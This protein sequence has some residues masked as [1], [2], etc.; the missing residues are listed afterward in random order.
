MTSPAF[1]PTFDMER[2]ADT[3]NVNKGNAGGNKRA[4]NW[5]AA[6]AEALGK[7]QGDTAARMVKLVDELN[8]NSEAYGALAGNDSPWAVD[9]KASLAAEANVLNA[10]LQGEGQMFKIQSE[11]TSTVIKSIGEGQSSVAR[12]Q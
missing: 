2:V 12:K 7:I 3:A 11:T 10:R 9:K 6:I 4:M 5:L 1:N 8:T